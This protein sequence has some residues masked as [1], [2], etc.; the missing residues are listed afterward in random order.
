MCGICGIYSDDKVERDLLVKMNNLLKHRGPDDEG[1]YLKDNF[2]FAMK[3]LSIID[4]K[5]GRQP[6]HSFDKR[7][8]IVFNGEIYNYKEL[9]HN[10]LRDYSFSTD[11]DTEVVV[12]LYHKFGTGSFKFLNGMFAIAIYDNQSNELIVARDRVGIK[13]VF[14]YY[15]NNKFL[16]ASEA[17]S[18]YAY[19][20][21]ELTINYPVLNDYFTFGTIPSPFSIYREIRKLEPGKFIKFDGR[22]LSCGKYWDY[23]QVKPLKITYSEA[24]EALKEKVAE[25]VKKEMVSDVPVGC[26]L[27]GGVDSSIVAY[28]MSRISP[29]TRN[30]TISFRGG[31]NKDEYYS[32]IFAKKLKLQHEVNILDFDYKAGI[33]KLIKHLGEPFAIQS[34]IPLMMNSEISATKNKVVLT[35]D[36]ADELFGG[37]N[38]HRI[39]KS[40]SGLLNLKLF[41][42]NCPEKATELVNKSVLAPKVKKGFQYYIY[43][44]LCSM[45]DKNIFH[46][47]ISF[48]AER[49]Y[50]AHN[51][52]FSDDIYDTFGQ[53]Q[54]TKEF[55]DVIDDSRTDFNNILEF[56]MRTTLI[57]E[58]LMK[59]D[60]ATM[61]NSQEAR[62][63]LI[64]NDLIEFVC[65]LPFEYKIKDGV[66]KS[67]LKDAYS[68]IIPHE[69]LY[70]PKRGFN[71]PYDY[72]LKNILYDEMYELLKQNYSVN[73]FKKTF[74]EKEFRNFKKVKSVLSAKT[75]LYLY[76]FLKWMSINGM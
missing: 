21:L 1:Y 40:I 12:N 61:I 63:P 3:R 54:Y 41:S 71:M 6:I 2:G 15:S 13:P 45:S 11:S 50:S 59:V 34:A 69:I 44:I 18:I 66:A 57:D 51:I 46:K 47:Y 75:F 23:S 70:A 16:F 35:G 27:S 42:R 33:D 53:L 49:D 52:I 28:E 39:F 48:F 65:G 76:F 9:K 8:T 64:N 5:T 74:I 7:Y 72:W 26:F 30:Y 58:M 29:D 22:F 55:A 4:L 14:Y 62:V 56:D 38:R 32:K 43:P 36:G 10:Y 20:G 17:K 24:Q 25:S 19:P 31:N 73:I 68:G 67:L 37:Y 60:T